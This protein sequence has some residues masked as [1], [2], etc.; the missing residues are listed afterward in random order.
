[1]GFIGEV[2]RTL[3]SAGQKKGCVLF[4]RRQPRRVKVF[5][6][7]VI[8]PLICRPALVKERALRLKL[9]HEKDY[10]YSRFDDG[11]GPALVM[12]PQEDDDAHGGRDLL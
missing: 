6:I 1:M 9:H 2:I 10:L 7:A 4:I 8:S 5:E 12:Q 11:R 3:V